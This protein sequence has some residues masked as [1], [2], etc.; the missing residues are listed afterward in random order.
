MKR[1]NV[2]LLSSFLALF[3]CDTHEIGSSQTYSYPDVK[4]VGAMKDV[5]WKGELAGNI[6]IDTISDKTGLYGLGPQSYLTG[7]IMINNGISFLSK[8]TS[9][10]TMSV[11]RRSDVSAPFFVYTHVTEWHETDL[12]KAIHTIQ[13]LE[14]WIDGQTENYKRPFAFKLTGQIIQASI[15]V[16]NLPEG[17]EVSSPDGAHQGQTNF[18]LTDQ[19][20][21]I[22]GFFSTEHKGIFTHHDS[23]LHM[24]LI[25]SDESEMGHL[26]ELEI[27]NMKLYLPKW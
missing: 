21:E 15:H 11:E 3:A 19:S 23:F 25:T 17:T 9:D 10:S 20:V 6:Y 12:P 13:D 14:A 4:V 22:V 24:H 26:D 7:E 18:D 8:V 2:L 16:Q 27:G 5:M 1:L